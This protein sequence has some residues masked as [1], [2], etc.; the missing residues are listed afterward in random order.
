MDKVI[1]LV[2]SV[3]NLTVLSTSLKSFFKFEI[4]QISVTAHLKLGE[5]ASH[6][7]EDIHYKHI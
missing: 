2:S 1:L 3:S 4:Q 6:K 7:R 5:N